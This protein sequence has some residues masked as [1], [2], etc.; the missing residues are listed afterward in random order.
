MTIWGMGIMLAPIFG[1]MIGGFLTENYNWRWVF[2]INL[3]IG[4]PTFL[5][6]WWLLPS[7]AITQRGF[8]IIGFSMLA[9]GLAALQLMLDRGQQVDWFDAWEIRIEAIVALS[10][11]WI[12]FLHSRWGK[13]PLFSTA[14]TSNA[15]FMIAL[16]FMLLVGI[17][18]MAVFALLPPMLQGLRGYSVLDTGIILAPRGL[19]MLFAMSIV[20]R[21]TMFVDPRVVIAF[22]CTLVATSLY[23]MTGWSLDITAWD[24]GVSGAIQGLGLG[25]MFMPLNLLAFSTLGPQHRTD[26]SSLSYLF[27]NLGGSIGISISTTLLARNIQINH[28]ELGGRITSFNLPSIDLSSVDRFGDVGE[29]A[30]RIADAQINQQAAMIAY[31]DDFKAMMVVTIIAIPFLM[32]LKVPKKAG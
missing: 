27:R 19:G 9:I 32:L 28:E 3:P 18:M 14:L 11:L 17:I 8:D 16:P 22:G 21:L 6:L 1:P 5:L 13:N 12:F 23:L 31:L 20:A 4:I 30:M 29:A 25:L 2:Y 10:A 26:G 24:I 15:N 7:R